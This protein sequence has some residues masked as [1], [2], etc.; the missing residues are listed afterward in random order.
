MRKYNADTESCTAT[1]PSDATSD[2]IQRCIEMVA[3]AAACSLG[4]NCPRQPECKKMMDVLRH[5]RACTLRT[6]CTICQQLMALCVTHARA[7]TVDS[8]AC[9]VPFCAELRRHI[10]RQQTLQRHQQHQM[11]DR[12]RALMTGTGAG[13]E[14]F[15][16]TNDRVDI[17]IGQQSTGKGGDRPQLPTSKHVL[18]TESNP[19][20]VTV[21]L[22]HS[23]ASTGTLHY[24]YCTTLPDNAESSTSAVAEQ[25]TPRCPVSKVAS[26]LMSNSS[27]GIQLNGSSVPITAAS[28]VGENV[29]LENQST[30]DEVIQTT[31]SLARHQMIVGCLR[32]LKKLN[33][34]MSKQNLLQLL[35]HCSRQQL[36]TLQDK[37][38]NFYL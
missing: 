6:S 12:R 15:L 1:K 36:S 31:Q 28:G 4:M 30:G 14:D 11:D 29:L 18:A 35:C 38:N 21:D 26:D 24:D 13:S 34:S 37:V 9:H 2:V 3:H 8:S 23:A 19:A 17:D 5:V 20:N 10:K 27:S 16:E 7:C 25:K 33:P 22:E 32:V